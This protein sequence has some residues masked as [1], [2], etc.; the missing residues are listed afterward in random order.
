MRCY[1]RRPAAYTVLVARGRSDSWIVLIGVFKLVKAG[2]LIAVSTGA[3]ELIHRGA[4]PLYDVLVLLPVERHSRLANWL[5][6]AVDSLTPHRLLLISIATGVYAALFLVEGI[7]LVLRKRW[8][9]IVTVII[10]GSFIPLE[11]YEAVKRA[12]VGKATIIAVN[13]AIV[14]YLVWRLRKARP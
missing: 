7:G 3:L 2:V 10:T 13:L 8:G 11:I 4:R 6:H 9:E 12:S 14:A 5:A 1:Q